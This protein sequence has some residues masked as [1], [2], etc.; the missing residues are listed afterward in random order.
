[1]HLRD[2][3]LPVDDERRVARQAQRGVQDGPVLGDVD[4][5]A[6]EHR[7]D[8]LRS[9]RLVRELQEQRDRLVRD[10]VLRVVE[11]E[12]GGLGGQPLAAGGVGGEQ[13]AQVRLTDAPR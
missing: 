11:V 3:V 12:P 6:A 5:V 10:P 7:L 1:M 4:V 2:D 13:V 9:P 8:A